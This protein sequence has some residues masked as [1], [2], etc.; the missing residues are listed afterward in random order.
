MCLLDAMT[1]NIICHNVIHGT[2][3]IVLKILN[4]KDD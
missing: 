4:N 2:Q 3:N 1:D